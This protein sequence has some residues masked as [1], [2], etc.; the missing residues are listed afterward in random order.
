MRSSD[1]SIW[2][3]IGEADAV[4]ITTNGCVK[5]NGR[6]V[7]GAGIAK[8]FLSR[9][10]SLDKTLGTSINK[11]GNVTNILGS[12]R[13]TCL[14]SFPTKSAGEIRD[15]HSQLVGHMNSKYRLGDFVPGWA[16]QSDINLIKRSASQLVELADH[17]GWKCVILPKPGCNNGGLNWEQ[18]VQPVLENVLDERLVILSLQ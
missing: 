12:D 3:Y 2:S 9:Y 15:E 16:L 7:M 17:F 6:A 10:P 18:T 5:S 1:R 13:G 8:E 11:Y 4:C 14:V